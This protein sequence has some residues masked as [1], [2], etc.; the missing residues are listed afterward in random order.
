M[1][2]DVFVS[3]FL[4]Q[5]VKRK[6]E[7][8]LFNLPH[9]VMHVVVFACVCIQHVKLPDTPYSPWNFCECPS[10]MTAYWTLACEPSIIHV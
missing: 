2:K 8:A 1:Q 7:M 9:T 6:F 5:N 3:Y 4:C 10:S